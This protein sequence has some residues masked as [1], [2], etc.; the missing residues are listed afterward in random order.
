[1]WAAQE[2]KNKKT[3][4]D[5]IITEDPPQLKNSPELGMLLPVEGTKMNKER[6]W[7]FQ[8]KNRGGGRED[9]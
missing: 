1:M 6:R 7:S 4:K 3:K 9:D 5:S 2:E 8:K